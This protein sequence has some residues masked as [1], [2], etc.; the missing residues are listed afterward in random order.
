MSRKTWGKMIARSGPR[1][2]LRRHHNPRRLSVFP[3]R[4]RIES[5]TI[6]R[7]LTDWWGRLG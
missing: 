5:L 2:G 1:C 6:Q 4:L 7:G 3:P